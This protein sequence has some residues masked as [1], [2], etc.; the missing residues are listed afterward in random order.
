M[1]LPTGATLAP[2]EQQRI[3]DAV[4]ALE[5]DSDAPRELYVRIGIHIH[6]EYPKHVVIGKN[7]DETPKV[8]VVNSASEEAALV[9]AP[10][11]EPIKQPEAESSNPAQEASE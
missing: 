8:A 7:E 2:G 11:A 6:H 5:K 9:P 3:N 10:A 1:E 4:A